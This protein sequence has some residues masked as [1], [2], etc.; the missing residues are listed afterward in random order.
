MVGSE[1]LQQPPEGGLIVNPA[2]GAAGQADQALG[3]LEHG[4]N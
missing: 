4:L 2:Q 3:V 1:G